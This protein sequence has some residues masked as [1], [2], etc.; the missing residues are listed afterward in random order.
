MINQDDI[1][2][3][4][5]TDRFD[6]GDAVNNFGADK[7]DPRRYHGGDFKGITDRIYYLKD[8]GITAL[9]ITPVYLSIGTL[10][11]SDGY[12]GYWALDFER[13]DPHLYTER[14]EYVPGARQYLKDLCE[15][16]HDSGI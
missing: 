14:S 6:D 9:W 2:Y 1:I 11:D 16:L 15:R 8:L 13:I 5:L 12:H 4:V 7:T 3:F 10:G